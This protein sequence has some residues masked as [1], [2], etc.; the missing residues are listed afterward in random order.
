MT[1]FVNT[2]GKLKSTRSL[3]SGALYNPCP[4]MS[5]TNIKIKLIIAYS[6]DLMSELKHLSCLKSNEKTMKIMKIN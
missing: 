3:I 2:R 1:V 6:R 5:R 4:P